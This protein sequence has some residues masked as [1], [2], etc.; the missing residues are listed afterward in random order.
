MAEV[1]ERAP[2]VIERFKR[3]VLERGVPL[4]SMVLFG[5]C[6]RDGVQPPPLLTPDASRS[7]RKHANCERRRRV[8]TR[9]GVPAMR[10][11][12]TSTRRHCS[13]RCISLAIQRL[14]QGRSRGCPCVPGRTGS[15]NVLRIVRI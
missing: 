6:T 15:R 14:C 3:L 12:S 11:R 13:Y 4:H 9:A 1:A 7:G 2:L 8:P 5:A 10:W